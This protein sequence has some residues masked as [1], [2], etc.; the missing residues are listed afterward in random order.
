MGS[1]PSITATLMNVRPRPKQHLKP[2]HMTDRFAG[3]TCSLPT[4]LLLA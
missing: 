1:E 2:L 4:Q 3:Q